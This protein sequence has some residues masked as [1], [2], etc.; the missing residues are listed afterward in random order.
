MQL[1]HDDL[2]CG[3]AL[4]LVH[5]RRDAAAII[6]DRDRSVGVQFNQH[7]IA[8]SGERFVDRVVRNFEHHVVQAAAV[9][10]VADIHSRPLAN[11]V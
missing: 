5:A 10:G 9:I 3:N 11:R 8:M 7:Q 4:F 6:F 2:S 1:S